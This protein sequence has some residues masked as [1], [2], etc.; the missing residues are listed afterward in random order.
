MCGHTCVQ[1]DGHV[2][3][4]R[5]VSRLRRTY[6]H[7]AVTLAVTV[8][9]CAWQVKGVSQSSPTYSGLAVFMVLLCVLFAGAWLSVIAVSMYRQYRAGAHRR[10]RGSSTGDPSLPSSSA[11]VAMFSLSGPSTGATIAG[12]ETGDTG[13]ACVLATTTLTGGVRTVGTPTA[14]V[15]VVA[16][17]YQAGAQPGSRQSHAIRA[18][19][20]F[21]SND[22][23]HAQT[24]SGGSA[25]TED[26]AVGSSSMLRALPRSSQDY[27]SERASADPVSETQQQPTASALGRAQA[28]ELLLNPLFS[29]V[30]PTPS[31]GTGGTPAGL[32]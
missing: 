28:G 14:A 19:R 29:R 16:A 2:P 5:C 10:R 6:I 4:R 23:A 3:V 20:L 11:P 24:E 13:G 1:S 31:R 30:P 27:H 17:G 25:V 22:V 15:S 9:V 18:R 8:M 7:S 32:Q 21:R 26:N 12:A